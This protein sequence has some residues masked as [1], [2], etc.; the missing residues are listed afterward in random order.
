ME[1]HKPKI[2]A[3]WGKE[4]RGKTHTLNLVATLLKLNRGATIVQGEIPTDL[5]EDSIYIIKYHK[6]KI[7]IATYGDDGKTLSKA[8]GDIENDCDLYICATRTKDSSVEF[9]RKEFYNIL[10]VE[11][12]G[13]T[14]EHCNLNNIDNLQQKTNELQAM[15]I[16]DVIDEI[17]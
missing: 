10:W 14:T 3:L 2:I 11:K 8:F 17:L 12:W 13:I 9:A 15:G 1:S 16:I 4:S 6:K 5:S 7:G